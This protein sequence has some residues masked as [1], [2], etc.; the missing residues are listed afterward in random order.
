MFLPGC[1]FVSLGQIGH[2]RQRKWNGLSQSQREGVSMSACV[3]GGIL[4][5]CVRGSGSDPDWSRSIQTQTLIDS[6]WII[7]AGEAVSR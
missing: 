5:G 3:R 2:G 6:G 7:R 1:Y 4:D